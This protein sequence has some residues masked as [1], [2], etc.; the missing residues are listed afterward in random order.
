MTSLSVDLDDKELNLVAFR[1]H[2]S[3]PGLGGQRIW[4]GQAGVEPLASQLMGGRQR[5]LDAF[6]TRLT[7][8]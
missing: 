8:V 7:L 5:K 6:I 2:G 3:S 1:Q 4:E